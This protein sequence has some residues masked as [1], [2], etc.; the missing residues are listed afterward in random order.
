VIVYDSLFD[1]YLT[2]LRSVLFE[3][4]NQKILCY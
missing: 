2:Q 3:M 1:I 4:E